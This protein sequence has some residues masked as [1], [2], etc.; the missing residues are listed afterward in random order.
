MELYTEVCDYQIM[1]TVKKNT[2][3]DLT[4]DPNFILFVRYTDLTDTFNEYIAFP[5]SIYE[6][7]QN[8]AF[9]SK[10]DNNQSLK[11]IQTENLIIITY[12]YK[13]FL[14]KLKNEEDYY[15]NLINGLDTSNT[16][17]N[18]EFIKYI[19]MYKDISV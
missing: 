9:L 14:K 8:T 7:V 15:D 18:D 3:I 17:V 10:V 16:N 19:N 11:W 6:I 4:S 2:P 12:A 1:G 13:D 5:L